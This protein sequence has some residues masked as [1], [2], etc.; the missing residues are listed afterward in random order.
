MDCIGLIAVGDYALATG[1]DRHVQ[2]VARLIA[3][4]DAV[5]AFASFVPADPV[6][7]A[8]ALH[9]ALQRPHAV[10]CLGGVGTHADDF[11]LAAVSAL[12]QGRREVGLARWPETQVGGVLQVGNIVLLPGS[13]E[14]A[15]A[16]FAAWWKASRATDERAALPSERLPWRLPVTPQAD[17][18]RRQI[19]A[20]YPLV[21]QR[22][23]CDQRGGIQL[24]LTGPSRGKTQAARKALQRLLAASA[25]PAVRAES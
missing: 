25:S 16:Q 10:A 22:L 7:I 12:Q 9:D 3:A 8:A 20:D 19:R 14:R 24:M 23:I 17:A 1:Q 11:V 21:R 2:A 18:A 4:E 13:V 6:A 15:H 5:L